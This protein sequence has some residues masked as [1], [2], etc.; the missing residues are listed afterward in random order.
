LVEGFVMKRE[1]KKREKAGSIED[2]ACLRRLLS[3]MALT[4]FRSLSL[5]CFL[6]RLLATRKRTCNRHDEDKD[7]KK[8]IQE[9]L[10]KSGVSREET[11]KKA[12]SHVAVERK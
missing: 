11:S 3:S 7:K 6:C 9:L 5:S 10:W 12:S 4:V 1:G 8:K 2:V